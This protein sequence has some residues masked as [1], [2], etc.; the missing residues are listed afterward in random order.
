MPVQFAILDW[1]EGPVSGAS[2]NPARSLG[3]AVIGA[4]WQ[5]WRVYWVGLALDAAVAIALVSFT[6]SGI[7]VRTRRAC[8]TSVIPVAP[9]LLAPEIDR[10][11]NEWNRAGWRR[12][13]DEL[14]ATDPAHAT[15]PQPLA[16]GDQGFVSPSLLCATAS[17]LVSPSGTQR[18]TALV[19]ALDAR[20]RPPAPKRFDPS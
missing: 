7:T 18:V 17:A 14:G 16:T 11:T 9:A 8:S 6:S 4:M 10:L 15:S 1:L 20:S 12:P 5:G 19:T 3:P 2:A 13:A